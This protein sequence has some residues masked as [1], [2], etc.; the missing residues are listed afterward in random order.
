MLRTSRIDYFSNPELFNFEENLIVTVINR[1][2]R[3]SI[4]FTLHLLC[5]TKSRCIRDI[6]PIV[7]SRENFNLLRIRSDARFLIR[8]IC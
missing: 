5:A 3:A 4:Y 1:T 8:L 2:M 7:L 6:V